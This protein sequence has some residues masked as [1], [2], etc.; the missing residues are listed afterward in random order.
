MR[1]EVCPSPWYQSLLILRGSVQHGSFPRA[2]ACRF[3][4][5]TVDPLLRT[6]GVR[7]DRESRFLPGLYGRL[8][9]PSPE[10]VNEKTPPLS[11]GGAES[12]MSIGAN[13]RFLGHGLEV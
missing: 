6:Q 1:T 13:G 8:R 4:F 3:R 5:G 2:E 9:E 12:I 10:F 7:R 11:L